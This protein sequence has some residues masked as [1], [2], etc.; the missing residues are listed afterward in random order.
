VNLDTV[1]RG[2]DVMTTRGLVPLDVEIAGGR[3]AS[4][5]PPGESRAA[6]VIDARG[7][8]LLAGVIDIHCHVRAPAFPERGTVASETR[9]A[10]AGGVTTLFEMP[11]TRPCCNSAERVAA[12]RAHFDGQA[13]VN[14]GLYA[15]PADISQQSLAAIRD[16]GT[17]AFK[18]FTTASPPGRDD[19]FEGLCYP[20]EAEQLAVLKALATTGLPVVVHAESASLLSHY[21]KLAAT[22]DPALA[23]T[24]LAARPAICEAAAVAR[25][26]TLN[27]EANA[28]LHIAHVT[29]RDTVEILRRFA[30]SSDF[31]AETCP[32]YLIKTN[33]DVGR[34][35]VSAKINPPIRD[36]ADQAALWSA[37]ADGTI[38][39]VTTDHATFARAEKQAAARNFPGAPAGSP[40]L[41]VLLPMML[42]AAAAGRLTLQQV[43]DLLS[44]NA[45]ARFGLPAK[46][47]IEPGA[48]A[49]LVLVDLRETT[50]VNAPDLLTQGREVAELYDGMRFRGRVITTI[51]GG[52]VVF[53]RGEI[54]AEAAGRY[55]SPQAEAGARAA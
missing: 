21:E 14:F 16:A 48:D 51:V 17:I 33:E 36:A 28:R 31:S 47:R 52:R 27:I 55:V 34:V 11:I 53:D 4:L 32:H 13:V 6:S 26:L 15:A 19:E 39:H 29:S 20:G 38:R 44:A 50:A 41:E 49:D 30:G 37:V 24:H 10:A 5:K 3:I 43:T 22:L 8:T 18:I 1:I 25:L 2:A 54:R 42:D 7:L 45:A 35:G 40:G 23:S 9:A 46:G 12:R